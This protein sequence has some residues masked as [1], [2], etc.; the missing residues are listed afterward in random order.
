LLDKDLK[1]LVDLCHPIKP[2][3][4]TKNQNRS[5]EPSMLN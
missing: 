5:T 2:D 3:Q 1:D 4:V